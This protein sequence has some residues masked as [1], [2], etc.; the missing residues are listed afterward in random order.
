VNF[1]AR[2]PSGKG[3]INQLTFSAQVQIKYLVFGEEGGGGTNV[4]WW[5]GWGGGNIGGG[6]GVN[7][8]TRKKNFWARTAMSIDQSPE[9]GETAEK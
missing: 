8:K 5:R 6:W 1:F 9:G 7:A 4:R 3:H 2:V